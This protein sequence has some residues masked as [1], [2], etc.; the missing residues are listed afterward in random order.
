MNVK[1]ARSIGHSFI[2]NFEQ[3]QMLKQFA[4]KNLIPLLS[5]IEADKENTKIISDRWEIVEEF[6]SLSTKNAYLRRLSGVRE[7][8]TMLIPEDIDVLNS[9]ITNFKEENESR[10]FS[11]R[12]VKILHSGK[13]FL[14]YDEQNNQYYSDIQL[15]NTYFFTKERFDG[16]VT[17]YRR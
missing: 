10:C 6:L 11:T 4:S 15:F 13:D 3:F 1:T 2:H 16:T 12:L 17:I 7:L 14:A 9:E 8:L 5:Q